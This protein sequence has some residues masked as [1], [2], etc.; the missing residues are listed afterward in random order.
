MRVCAERRHFTRLT[1]WLT[2]LVSSLPSVTAAKRAGMK[3]KS[4]SRFRRCT[5]IF[6]R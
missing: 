6:C 4:L 3:R 5:F 2:H 1:F